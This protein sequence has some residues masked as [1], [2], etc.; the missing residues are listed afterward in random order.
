[1]AFWSAVAVIPNYFPD[2][3]NNVFG[4]ISAT[5]SFGMMVGPPII[6]FL[7]ENYGWKSAMLLLG[8]FNA[9]NIV[10][11]AL[12]YPIDEQQRLN[13]YVSTTD[14]DEDE[15]VVGIVSDVNS[16]N[17]KIVGL[18]YDGENDET[19]ET[20]T[21]T[22]SNLRSTFT[23]GFTTFYGYVKFIFV[24]NYKIIFIIIAEVLSAMLAT[25]WIIFLVPHAQ[26]RGISPQIG[27]FLSTIGAAGM[28]LGRAT[29]GPMIQNGYVTSIQLYIFYGLVNAAAFFVDV[30]VDQFAI[31]AIL[32][33]I[34]GTFTGTM[35]ILSFPA[36][37]EILGERDAVLGYSF[38]S[39]FLIIGNIIGGVLLG[40]STLGE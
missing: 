6:G 28:V 10:C 35:T 27:A 22:W 11:G 26:P 21:C 16:D 38:V 13:G 12:Y 15:N 31:L 4:F 2:D 23:R 37:V 18:V 14:E 9:N 20:P 40:K 24:D 3:I 8:A 32:A 36:T 29:M 34:N 25:G 5:G 19:C 1:M 17:D 39:S 7:I 33:F 30:F